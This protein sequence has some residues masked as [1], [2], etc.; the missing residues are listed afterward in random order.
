MTEVP[1]EP[2]HLSSSLISRLNAALIT[3]ITSAPQKHALPLTPP[4]CVPRLLPDLFVTGARTTL[5]RRLATPS[6]ASPELLSY[7]DRWGQRWSF[8]HT[9][10]D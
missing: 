1:I 6:P 9:S 7:L 4:G 10:F 3:L 8:S 5:P 2:C